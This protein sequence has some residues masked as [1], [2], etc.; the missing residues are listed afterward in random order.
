[1]QRNVVVLPQPLG[2][3]ARAE[4]RNEL[5]LPDREVDIVDGDVVARA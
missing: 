2:P 3:S 4:Q 1:M 5:A